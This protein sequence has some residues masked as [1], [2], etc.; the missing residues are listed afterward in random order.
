LRQFSRWN[1]GLASQ[2]TVFFNAMASRGL[3]LPSLATI[4]T[5]QYP[6]T[7]GVHANYYRLPDKNR[8]LA[9]ILGFY[10]YA[11]DAFLANP[12]TWN[13]D[14]EG[15]WATWERGKGSRGSAAA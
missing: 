12:I 6:V 15:F 8:H 2:G 14:W 13:R 11:S 7:H 4:M 1:F 10:G 3:T 5:G 9:E